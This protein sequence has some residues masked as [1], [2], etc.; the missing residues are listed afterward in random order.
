MSVPTCNVLSPVPGAG[1]GPNRYRAPVPD[2]PRLLPPILCSAL[3]RRLRILWGLE[4]PKVA[5]NPILSPT[6]AAG[7]HSAAVNP[8]PVQE[9]G[10]G[11]KREQPD[12]V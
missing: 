4:S 6:A 9:K 10:E 11:R 3:D 12:A 2:P 8:V 1:P 5:S 7:V